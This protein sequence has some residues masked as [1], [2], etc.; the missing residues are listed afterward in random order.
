MSHTGE[1]IEEKRAIVQFPVYTIRTRQ[2]L[3]DRI[4]FIGIV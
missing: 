4:F 1:R 3:L 2:T